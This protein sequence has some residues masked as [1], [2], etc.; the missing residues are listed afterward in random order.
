[1]YF[2]HMQPSISLLYFTLLP[3]EPSL[4]NTSHSYVHV[5]IPLCLVKVAC[6]HLNS[7]GV[8]YSMTGSLA[9]AIPLSDHSF[10]SKS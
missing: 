7:C 10:P 1:M 9:V 8:T 6:L 3:L 2:D 4:S 5:Y